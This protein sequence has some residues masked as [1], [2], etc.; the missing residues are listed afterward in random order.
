MTSAV[1][2]SGITKTFPG[3]VAN[4]NIDFAV[5]NAEIHGLLGENG[6]GKTVLMSILYGRVISAR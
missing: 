6:A 2:M 4:D 1:E 3:V 5:E